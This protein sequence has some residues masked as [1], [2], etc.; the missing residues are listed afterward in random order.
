MADY[1]WNQRAH[2]V[3]A[4]HHQSIDLEV[5]WHIFDECVVDVEA[6]ARDDPDDGHGDDVVQDV[7]LAEEEP[8]CWRLSSIGYGWLFFISTLSRSSILFSPV[9]ESIGLF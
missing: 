9:Y 1:T 6:E 5:S 7:A 8:H 2:H 4:R 3:S